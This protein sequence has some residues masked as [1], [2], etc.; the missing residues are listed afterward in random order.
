MVSVPTIP[1]IMIPSISI[2]IQIN[3]P[4]ERT[5]KLTLNTEYSLTAPS[6]AHYTKREFCSITQGR[7]IQKQPSRVR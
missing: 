7:R 5:P 6:S 4:H 1:S 2:R 3:T